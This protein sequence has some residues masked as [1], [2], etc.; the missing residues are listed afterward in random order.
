[1]KVSPL[2]RVF[3]SKGLGAP[4]REVTVCGT[5]SWSTHSRV[6]LTPM[7]TVT[8]GGWKFKLWSVPTPFGRIMIT[9]GTSVVVV[10]VGLFSLKG[11]VRLNASTAPTERARLSATMSTTAVVNFPGP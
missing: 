7:T 1:M 6:L 8:I 9:F 5:G 2:V 4:L 11:G 3:E 10:L